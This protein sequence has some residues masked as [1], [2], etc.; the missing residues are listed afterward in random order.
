ME[1][2]ENVLT[3]RY[4]KGKRR[5]FTTRYGRRREGPEP[6]GV[7]VEEKGHWQ[8]PSICPAI[9]PAAAT[10]FIMLP[11][12]TTFRTWRCPPSISPA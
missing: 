1:G 10:P 9:R 2:K 3:T 5:A 6:P 7:D 11:L 8:Y 12:C 4:G